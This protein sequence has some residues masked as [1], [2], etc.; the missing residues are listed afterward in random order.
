[1]LCIAGATNIGSVVTLSSNPQNILI[2]S[3]SGIHY[4][5]F[6]QAMTPIAVTGLA[7]QVILLS[8]LYPNV[9][10]IVP[11][12]HLPIKKKR[13]FK[14]LFNKTLIITTGLLIALAGEENIIDIMSD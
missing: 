4:L 12:E 6:M 13:V 7:I 11:C 9:R 3:F 10:S 14:P 5:D 8:L 2:G 1:V